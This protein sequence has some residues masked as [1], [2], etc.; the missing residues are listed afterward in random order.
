[1]LIFSNFSVLSQEIPVV[2]IGM[3]DNNLNATA[4]VDIPNKNS[5]EIYNS[6]LEWIAYNYTN[7][8]EV[9]QAKVE[10]KM[11]RMNGIST[12]TIGP[13]MGFYFDLGYTLE[14]NIKDEKLRFIANNLE[15]ISQ[16]SPYTRVSLSNLYNRKGELRKAKRYSEVKQK[17]DSK[18]T[19]IL[20][21][22]IKYINGEK[23]SDSDW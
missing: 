9:I 18:L 14:F 6:L 3:T 2:K 16:Q 19:E 10:D 1:M 21:A 23:S 20:G 13:V 22:A 4:I 8:D 11:I 12:S 15:Q 7:T 5:S 17:V